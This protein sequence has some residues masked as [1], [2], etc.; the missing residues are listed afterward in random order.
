M[1][2]RLSCLPDIA[3]NPTWMRRAL[4]DRTGMQVARIVASGELTELEGRRLCAEAGLSAQVVW[5]ELDRRI[6]GVPQIPSHHAV[7]LVVDTGHTVEQA[8]EVLHCT[9][10]HVLD[11]IRREQTGRRAAA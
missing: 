8:A 6:V 11:L 10:E 9:P 2:L 1:M 3:R 5:V 4:D 7:A